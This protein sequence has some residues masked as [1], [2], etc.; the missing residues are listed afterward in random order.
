MQAVGIDPSTERLE[1]AR[2]KYSA[3]NI[4]YIEASAENIPEIT[5][6]DSYDYVFSNFVLHW[7]KD[8]DQVFK[9]V[10]RVLKKGGKFGF[11]ASVTTEASKKWL[12]PSAVSAEYLAA[13]KE[14]HLAVPMDE[15]LKCATTHNLEIL[16]SKVDYH[17]W[18][19]ADVHKYIDALFMHMNGEFDKSHFNA[20]AAQCHFGDGEIVM[21][22]PFAI[23]IVKKKEL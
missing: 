18:K 20:E 10:H 22:A 16:H 21:K 17:E 4:E 14:R 13:A 8:K 7:C 2:D 6:I 12:P 11:V 15:Y 1:I 19:F 5:G 3:D 23:V 9:E